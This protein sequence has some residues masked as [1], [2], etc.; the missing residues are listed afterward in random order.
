MPSLTEQF[1]HLPTGRTHFRVD[2]PTDG[3]V[4]VLIHGATLP[5]FVWDGLAEPLADAG[6]RVVRYDLLG[7]GASTAPS[8]AY[9]A[10][11]F[12][13]QL[14]E[15]LQKLGI[16]GPVHLV[17]L[18]FGALIAA[19]FADRHPQ[20]VASLTYLAPDGF[21]VHTTRLGRLAS[22]PGIGELLFRLAGTRILLSRLS[23]YSHRPDVVDA[24][25][26]KF[27]PYASAPGFQRSLLSSIRRMPIHD[28]SALYARVDRRGIPTLVLWGRDDHVTPLP[29]QS[30]LLATLPAAR[31]K[32]LDGTGHL[33]HAERPAET[34]G[35]VI[36]FLA[37]Q[38]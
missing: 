13:A 11:L 25:S 32:I 17:A 16:T 18:A 6:F 15:L 1:L 38:A 2:G 34:S 35:A 27:R 14:G 19:G 37:G 7:R 8:V 23:A 5:M 10:D 26:A 21:G 4:V 31:M 30:R 22:L 20:D 3:P 9:D 12:D 24:V 33:P 36:G 28:A 29:E